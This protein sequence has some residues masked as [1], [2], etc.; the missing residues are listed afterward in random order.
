MPVWGLQASRPLPGVN[1]K[2][3]IQVLRLMWK[4]RGCDAVHGAE[5]LFRPPSVLCLFGPF[6]FFLFFFVGVFWLPLSIFA[7]YFFRK[8]DDTGSDSQAPFGWANVTRT[9]TTGSPRRK[10][11][12]YDYVPPPTVFI[13]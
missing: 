13:N 2:A 1:F 4:T 10:R 7:G 11:N 5:T 8:Q 6:F 9:E 3:R 12:C